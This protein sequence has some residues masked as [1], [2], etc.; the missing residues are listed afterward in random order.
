MV[1]VWLIVCQQVY[2]QALRHVVA[3]DTSSWEYR[4]L[5]VSPSLELR[6]LA[7]AIAGT[8][9]CCCTLAHT[10]INFLYFGD[11]FLGEAN[12]LDFLIFC[13]LEEVSRS[14]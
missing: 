4:T 12:N 2:A 13:S 11:L 9:A 5:V 1:E 14:C 10:R 6:R 8:V 3:H 7:C